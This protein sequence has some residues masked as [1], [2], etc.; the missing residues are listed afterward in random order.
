MRRVLVPIVILAVLLIAYFI[1]KSQRTSS[2]APERQTNYLQLIPDMVDRIQI[3]R[4]GRTVELV[5]REDGWHVMVDGEP[6]LADSK[7]VAEAL[8][9]A[10]DVEVGAVESENPQ[11][12][13]LYQV[14]TISGSLVQFYEDDRMLTSVIVGK[15]AQ[16]PD[17]SYVRKPGSNK[18]YRAKGM[19]SYLFNKPVNGWREKTIIQVDTSSLSALEFKYQDQAFMLIRQDTIWNLRVPREEINTAANQDSVRAYK[20]LLANLQTDDF[21]VLPR[22]SAFAIEQAEAYLLLD[23]R[24]V[25]GNTDWIK[26]YDQVN[27]QKRYYLMTSGREDVFVLYSTK[28]DQIT[29]KYDIFK[30]LIEKNG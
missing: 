7:Q 19:R 24:Y 26:V 22:D 25:D 3:E 5:E 27:D 16:M 10:S 1:V 30:T 28:F 13:A 12:Q 4:A 15:N 29:R 9:M 20:R 11:R 14:D 21:Y 17:Y 8:S 6:R 2:I 18:V 23:I